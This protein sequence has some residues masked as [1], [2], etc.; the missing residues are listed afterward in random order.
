MRLLFG[1]RSGGMF[2]GALSANRFLD[3]LPPFWILEGQAHVQT[4]R[5]L[6]CQV[7]GR[8]A[9]R[10]SGGKMGNPQGVSVPIRA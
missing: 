5:Q 8:T 7:R 10:E 2:G 1:G 4:R 3:G 9:P 6:Q